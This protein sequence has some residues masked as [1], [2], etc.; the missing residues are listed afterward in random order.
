MLTATFFSDL[1]SAWERSQETFWPQ[2]LLFLSLTVR[3]LG[4]ALLAGIP[5]GVILS[6]LPRLAPSMIAFLAQLQ[7]FPSMVLL[8]LCIP[9]LG[10]GQ[11]PALFAAI[12]YSL[13]PIILN[14]CVGITQVSPAVR[15]AAR[16]MGMTGTQV[17]WHVELPLALPVILAGVRTGALG[18]IGIIVIGSMIGAGGLGDY[19]FNGM[20]RQDSGLI[21]LGTIPILLLTVILFWGL[22]GIAWLSK[23]NSSLGMSLGGGLILVLSGYAGYG[24]LDRIL[25]PR[26]TQLVVGARDFT[27]GQILAEIVKQVLQAQTGLHI[28]IASNLGTPLALKALSSGEI[29]LY[30]EYTGNLLTS[31]EG[32]DLPVPADKST[33]TDLVRQEMRKRYG[34]VLLEPL[35]LNN[36]YAPCVTRETARRYRLEQISDLRRA[37]QLRVVIDLSFLTR[38]DGWK[39][40]VQK[41]NLHFDKA[42]RQVS[43]N[44]LYKALEQKEADLVIGFATDWQIESLDLVVLKDD[45]GYFPNYHAVPLVRES[46]LKRHPQIE[47]ALHLLAGKIDDQA[48]RRLNYQVAVEKRSEADVATEFLRAHGLLGKPR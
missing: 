35:G 2:T 15:D 5:T 26:R 47:S 25:Q 38:P 33:I 27:E 16:G 23:R 9:F 37:R 20:Y 45:L 46:V 11:P 29:D 10:I 42:P 28:E 41:Y 19:V 3:A 1:A 31:K 17:L 12:V 32:L 48:M 4:L 6:R 7:T 39:G 18:V 24:V 36:T 22:G 34:L 43:P 13:F 21:W 44:L 8:A 14:T 30:P 40:F